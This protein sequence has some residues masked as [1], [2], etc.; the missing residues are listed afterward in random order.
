VRPRSKAADVGPLLLTAYGLDKVELTLPEELKLNMLRK[1]FEERPGRLSNASVAQ[2]EAPAQLVVIIRDN[3]LHMPEVVA[4]SIRGGSDLYFMRSNCFLG[5]LIFGETDESIMKKGKTTSTPKSKGPPAAGRRKEARPR[6][7]QASHRRPIR[8]RGPPPARQLARHIPG[9]FRLHGILLG[10]DRQR[11]ASE[12]RW[13]REKQW[14]WGAEVGFCKE[15]QAGR[16]WPI[17]GGAEQR[18]R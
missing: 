16:G 7:R 10:Q 2:P 1:R 18:R 11:H 3:P 14:F 8:Q 13:R 4:R 9:R 6:G 17:G 12:G 5:E 15:E